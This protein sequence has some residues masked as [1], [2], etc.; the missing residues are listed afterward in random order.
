MGKL[1]TGQTIQKLRT[2]RQ[3]RSFG[4]NVSENGEGQQDQM[5]VEGRAVV[6]DCP[7]VLFTVDGNDYSE[8]VDRHAFEGTQM[9]DVIFNYNHSG[10]VMARTKNGTLQLDV[11]DD[12][13]YV[14]ARLDG[15]AEGREIYQNIKDGY[16]DKMSYQYTVREE[17]YDSETRTSCV[18]K[19]KRLYD[20]SA[21]DIPAYDNTSIEARRDSILEAEA[22]AE[23]AREALA[24][25]ERKRKAAAELSERKLKLAKTF[26]KEIYGGDKNE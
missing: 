18:Q 25:D 8:T 7:T 3:Y 16:I 22:A 10:H 11:R 19:I 9:D 17:A 13:L 14:R 1:E 12:G 5:W 4:V 20:V 26:M 21:V 24:E 6:F 2:N 15:T 23:K